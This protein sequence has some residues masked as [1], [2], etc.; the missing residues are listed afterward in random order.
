M[1]RG[2]NKKKRLSCNHRGFTFSAN[3]TEIGD[4]KKKLEKKGKPVTIGLIEIW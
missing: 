3:K 4:K 1:T 2:G